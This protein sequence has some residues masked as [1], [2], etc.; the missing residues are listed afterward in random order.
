[1]LAREFHR[2]GVRVFATARTTENLA[3]LEKLG[4]QCLRLNV[5]DHQS[6]VDCFT[7]VKKALGDEGLSFLVNNAGIGTFLSLESS[8]EKW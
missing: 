8:K 7:D 3:D 1:M 6:I 2:N 4:I 5:D